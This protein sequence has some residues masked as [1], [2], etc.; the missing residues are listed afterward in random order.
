LYKHKSA[1]I[2]FYEFSTELKAAQIILVIVVGF[3]GGWGK[4]NYF[5][6]IV[7]GYFLP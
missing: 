2:I 7:M 5:L 4:Y 6:L 1:G 3:I